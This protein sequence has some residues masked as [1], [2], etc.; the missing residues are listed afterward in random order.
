MSP[1]KPQWHTLVL[2]FTVDLHVSYISTIYII[3]KIFKSLTR[4]SGRS[5][6]SANKGLLERIGR[7]LDA[8]L[9]EMVVELPPYVRGPFGGY[10]H[11]VFLYFYTTCMRSRCSSTYPPPKVPLNGFWNKFIYQVFFPVIITQVLLK[12]AGDLC[13]FAPYT[14][15]RISRGLV[16]L[17]RGAALSILSSERSLTPTLWAIA[18]LSGNWQCCIFVHLLIYLGT[19]RN[20]PPASSDCINLHGRTKIQH[21]YC[22]Y[23]M[24]LY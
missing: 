7:Y 12:P 17:A 10:S 1:E 5:I 6:V 9:K 15:C 21:C 2:C 8:L 23:F 19:I 24:Q 11:R 13:F 4:P 20:T 14:H 22:G 16:R 3:P 18:Y